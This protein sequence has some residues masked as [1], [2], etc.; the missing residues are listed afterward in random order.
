MDASQRQIGALWGR[1][2]RTECDQQAYRLTN[3]AKCRMTAVRS[4]AEVSPT[5]QESKQ[6]TSNS[7]KGG[8][9]SILSYLLC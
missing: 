5:C 7:V 1:Q 9:H 4:K 2:G 8:L 6:D 3:D